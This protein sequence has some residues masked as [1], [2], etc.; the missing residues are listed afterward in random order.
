MGEPINWVGREWTPFATT[1]DDSGGYRLYFSSDHWH[2]LPGWQGLVDILFADWDG[3]NWTN[4][5]NIGIPI[6]SPVEDESACITPDGQTLYFVTRRDREEYS[7]KELMVSHWVP[8]SIRQPE[9]GFL[10]KEVAINI[11]PNPFNATTQIRLSGDLSQVDRVTIYDLGGRL[12]TTFAPAPK[13]TWAGT[14]QAGDPVPS[15]IYFVKAAGQQKSAVMK[16]TLLR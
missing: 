15:G 8:T 16:V 6:N 1:S 3:Q 10:P 12:V 5:S 13:I 4:F 7:D 9:S 14:N 2:H 11:Y